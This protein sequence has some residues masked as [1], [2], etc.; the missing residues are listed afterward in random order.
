MPFDQVKRYEDL[1]WI[2]DL[3]RENA[4]KSFSVLEVGGYLRWGGQEKLLPIRVAL[5]QDWTVV[6]DV[7]PAELQ[8]YVHGDGC[9]LPFKDGSFEIVTALD[10]LEHIPAESRANFVRELV[11]VS[12]QAIILGGPFYSRENL[13]AEE[14]LMAF[15]HD[16]F[17]ERH[18]ALG[19]HLEF[20]LPEL[21]AIISLLETSGLTT[22]QI[23]SGNLHIWTSLMILRHFLYQY[24]EADSL[25]R[26]LDR[27]YT[28]FLAATDHLEP[29][30]RTVIVATRK[31]NSEVLKLTQALQERKALGSEQLA[32][33][34]MVRLFELIGTHHFAFVQSKKPAQLQK[35]INDQTAVLEDRSQHIKALEDHCTHLEAAYQATNQRAEDLSK[36]LSKVLEYLS[37]LEHDLSQRQTVVSALTLENQTLTAKITDLSAENSTLRQFLDEV[38]ATKTYRTLTWLSKVARRPRNEPKP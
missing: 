16:L 26:L 6:L 4:A 2:L 17:V 38:T 22:L 1:Q 23:G 28:V 7:K 29:T 11:R 33:E 20:G 8:D 30:Y 25:I 12:S 10:T 3:F 31:Q 19:E 27:Y 35:I 13:L 32:Y 9:C 36:E 15:L 14:Y 5:P 34:V 24:K 18:E 37:S 21:P